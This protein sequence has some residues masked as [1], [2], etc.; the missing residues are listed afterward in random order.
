MTA[1]VHFYYPSCR[2]VKSCP[3]GFYRTASPT[4]PCRPGCISDSN[5]DR[6]QRCIIRSNNTA[7]NCEVKFKKCIY[8]G[9]ILLFK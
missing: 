5:C 2:G 6:Q 4:V 9:V 1:S 8:I 3:P 7:G